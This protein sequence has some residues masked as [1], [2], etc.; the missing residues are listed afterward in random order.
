MALVVLI[1][2]RAVGYEFNSVVGYLSYLALYVA[3]P[4]SVAMYAVNR[5][6]LSLARMFALALPTGFALEIFTFLS[7]AALDAKGA[8]PWAPVVWVT[9]AIGIRFARGE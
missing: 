7:L 6:P 8:Y 2:A 1:M 5:G 4:G 9:L 3:L